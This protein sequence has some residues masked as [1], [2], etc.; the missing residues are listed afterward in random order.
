MNQIYN[1]ILASNLVKPYF[2][3]L[4]ISV[5][6]YSVIFSIILTCYKL[7]YFSIIKFE[8]ALQKRFLVILIV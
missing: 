2:H 1:N 4:V 5:T 7:L 8:R 6:F 3:T